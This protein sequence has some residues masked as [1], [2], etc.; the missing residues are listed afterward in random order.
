M[1]DKA[2]DLPLQTAKFTQYCPIILRLIICHKVGTITNTNDK[3]KEKT[4]YINQF[5]KTFWI[6]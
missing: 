5:R 1:S 2:Q 3:R 6:T 4:I